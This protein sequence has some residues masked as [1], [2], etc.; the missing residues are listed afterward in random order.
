[1]EEQEYRKSN[2]GGK[3]G[4]AMKT[5]MKISLEC[6]VSRVVGVKAGSGAVIEA[7]TNAEIG[8]EEVLVD[9]SHLSVEEFFGRAGIRRLRAGLHGR[10]L[11]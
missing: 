5:G 10:L 8:V 2:K 7:N 11:L 4:T 3:E 6:S 1:M 9:I